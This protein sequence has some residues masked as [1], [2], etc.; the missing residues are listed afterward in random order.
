MSRCLERLAD[1]ETETCLETRERVMG[2]M[3]NLRSSTTVGVR[4]FTE[5]FYEVVSSP[6]THTAAANLP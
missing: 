6:S 4:E 3:K 5:R 1:R 2:Q